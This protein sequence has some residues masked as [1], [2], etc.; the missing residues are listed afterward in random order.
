[1][2]KPNR[3]PGSPCKDPRKDCWIGARP[4]WL[5]RSCRGQHQWELPCCW[6]AFQPRS[7]RNDL[8]ISTFADQV[9]HGARCGVHATD[10]AP[11]LPTVHRMLSRD[12]VFFVTLLTQYVVFPS[13]GDSVMRPKGEPRWWS[14]KHCNAS[15]WGNQ[16][17][18][19]W[20]HS[21]SWWWGREVL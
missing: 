19:S 9:E 8:E 21:F 10:S 3:R 16:H 17:R 18:P 1:M 14:W 2:A 5:P 13:L 15:F 11:F 12:L 7:G 20:H 4:A 6:G